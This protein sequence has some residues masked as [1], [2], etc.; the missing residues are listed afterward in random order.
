MLFNEKILINGD[1]FYRKLIGIERYAFE[2]IGRIDRL[3][4]PREVSIIVLA[5]T[6][7]IPPYK[8]L[9]IIRHKNH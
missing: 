1:F 5:N 9:E 8:N 4:S 2:I 6:P 3:I 7:G